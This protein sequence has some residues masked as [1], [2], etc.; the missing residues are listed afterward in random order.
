MQN[1]FYAEFKERERPKRR[2][3]IKINWEVEIVIFTFQEI[4]KSA[5]LGVS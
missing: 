5:F 1:H 3:N 4:E 2:R